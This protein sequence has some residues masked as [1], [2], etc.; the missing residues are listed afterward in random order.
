MAVTARCTGLLLTGDTLYPGRL[1]VR[2]WAAFAATVGRLLAFAEDY[3][4]RHLRGTS[5]E[6]PRCRGRPP[7]RP[8]GVSG[9]PGG[10]SRRRSGDVRPSAERCT[11][12]A[13]LAPNGLA[14]T[15]PG[16][17]R[18]WKKYSTVRH[19]TFGALS[20]AQIL[21]TAAPGSSTWGC[22]RIPCTSE[23]TALSGETGQLPRC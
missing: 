10:L 2:D 22:R 16:R 1:Y 12:L 7:A 19:A 21:T 17:P 15:V 14:E 11:G 23:R 18:Q 4:V 20:P 8:A 9:R 6:L 3:P 5:P 13:W